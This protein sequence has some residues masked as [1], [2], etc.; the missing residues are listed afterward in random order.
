MSA[1]N[2]EIRLVDGRSGTIYGSIC[3]S[4]HLSSGSNEAQKNG[5]GSISKLVDCIIAELKEAASSQKLRISDE[6]DLRSEIAVALLLSLAENRMNA[7]I[8]VPVM[9]I[10][11][12][13]G[14]K[15]N[16]SDQ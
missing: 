9:E 4:I 2:L 16:G 10:K 3:R 11:V 13:E 14:E 7:S 8:D 12:E 15:T 6:R 1:L 5:R